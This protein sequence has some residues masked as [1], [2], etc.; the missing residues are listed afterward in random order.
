MIGW[1]KQH[2]LNSLK[3]FTLWLRGWRFDFVAL[4]PV[5]SPLC[6]KLFIT[7]LWVL[8]L[9]SCWK[10]VTRSPACVCGSVRTWWA[11]SG[12]CVMTTLRCKLWAGTTMR[13]A[14][15]RSKAAREY[16]IYSTYS[17]WFVYW[18]GN[19]FRLI[20]L[21][22]PVLPAGCATSTLVIVVI[23]TSWNATAT[24]AST[25][26]TG[27]SAPMLTPPRSSPSVGSST[28][29][30]FPFSVSHLFQSW[31]FHSS[32]LSFTVQSSLPGLA[33]ETVST[34]MSR[35]QTFFRFIT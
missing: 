17:I 22:Y 30:N 16:L 14:P 25:D 31:S 15:W 5:W 19:L 9:F 33:A 26:A 13:S 34:F 8:F 4:F 27:S 2:V 12:R 11:D 18:I 6:P 29:K 1:P 21:I 35:V 23:S 3:A 32:G 10:S 7:F 20:G 24:E 28:K